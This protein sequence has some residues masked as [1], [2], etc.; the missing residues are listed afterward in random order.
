MEQF[1]KQLILKAL[2]QPNG[3]QA[4]AARLAGLSYHPFRYYYPKMGPQTASPEDR[5]SA[6]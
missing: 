3:N 4:E 5:L 2:S 6:N 1:K